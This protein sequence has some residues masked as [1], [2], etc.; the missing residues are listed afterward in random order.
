VSSDKKMKERMLF[1]RCKFEE[2]LSPK[3]GWR[4]PWLAAVREH[5]FGLVTYVATKSRRG[6]VKRPRWRDKECSCRKDDDNRG[7]VLTEEKNIVQLGLTSTNLYTHVP[8]FLLVASLLNRA[9]DML[10][11]Y[12]TYRRKLMARRKAL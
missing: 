5:S 4:S 1:A 7:F 11:A 12:P 9:S 8:N 6:F 10:R 2:T 3:C